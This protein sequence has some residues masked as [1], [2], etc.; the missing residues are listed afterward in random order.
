MRKILRVLGVCVVLGGGAYAGL[1]YYQ[2]SQEEQRIRKAQA[3]AREAA[4]VREKEER[5]L[6]SLRP[7]PDYA[8]LVSP[9]YY[10]PPKSAWQAGEKASYRKLLG[11][12]KFDVLVVPFQ[13]QQQA[14]DRASRSL[15][16][17]HLA[18]ALASSGAS[19][20]DPYVVS[21]ALGDGARG[22]PWSEIELLA[23][24]MGARKIVAGYVGHD[25]KG[26]LRLTIRHGTPGKLAAVTAS[27]TKTFE[28]VPFTDD[29]PPFESFATLLPEVLKAIGTD[30]SKLPALP[31]I[32]WD[33][34]EVLPASPVAM[35]QA[36]ANLAREAGFL[37][38]LAWLT[39]ED[40]ERSRE[41]FAEKAM[42]SV[43]SVAPESLGYAE[44]R[45]RSY[46]LLGYRAAA[47]K[48]LGSSQSREALHLRAMLDGNY[49]E[50]KRL[51][52]AVVRDV[53]ALIARLEQ[54]DIAKTYGAITRKDGEN[55]ARLLKLPP[56]WEYFAVRAF[57]EF[58]DWSQFDNSGLKRIL[59][60]EMP[61]PGASLE[62]ML[63]GVVALGDLSKLQAVRDLAVMEHARKLIEAD[64]QAICC[65]AWSPRLSRLDFVHFVEA[66]ATDNLA[67]RAVF[68]EYIQGTPE[69]ALSFISSIDSIFRDHPR[70]TLARAAAERTIALRSEGVVREGL[71]KSAFL[72]AYHAYRWE[73]GITVTS[74]KAQSLVSIVASSL[75]RSPVPVLNPTFQDYPARAYS[76]RQPPPLGIAEAMT[77]LAHSSYDE[78]P[79]EVLYNLQSNVKKD[80]PAFEATLKSIEHRFQGS[81]KVALLRADSSAR[82][83]DDAAAERLYRE[84]IALQPSNWNAHERLGKM[85]LESGQPAKAA[86]LFR[87]FG[88]FKA[89]S[90]EDPVGIANAAYD[91]G[92]LLY[93]SGNLREASPLYEIAAR[94]KT[95]A[96][97]SLASA[98][99]LAFMKGDLIRG[100]AATIQ[101]VQRY[102]LPLAYRDYFAILHAT[103]SSGPAWDGFNSL[104][105]SVNGPQLWES[106]L[107]GHAVTG[108]TA[109]GIV[110]WISQPRIL[111]TSAE[112]DFPAMHLLRLGVMDRVPSKELAAQLAE[113][114]RPTWRVTWSPQRGMPARTSDVGR[115]WA[116][117]K[118]IRV[119]GPDRGGWSLPLTHAKERVVVK[120]DYEYF[121]TAYRQLRE[122][123]H[124]AAAATIEE[125]AG[126]YDLTLF[127]NA[128]FLPYYAF[129]TAK[130][131]RDVTGV[132]RVMQR[133]A[134]EDR[135]FDYYL[136]AAVLQA[137]TGKHQ[138]AL[139]SLNLARHRRPFTEHR[140]VLTEYQYAETCELLFEATGQ[141]QYRELALRWARNFQAMQPWFAWPYAV[142]AK[143]A[144]N[145]GDRDRAIAM[146]HY[147]DRNSARLASL[148]L[149]TVKAAVSA[150]RGKNPFLRMVAPPQRQDRI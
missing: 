27:N 42:I 106:V 88:G 94:L 65:R 83:G 101:R 11:S 37:Q 14:L 74:A 84:V 131:G 57:A 53:G 115:S 123:D 147:L 32:D 39:P 91:A 136:A 70:L 102:G 63:R 98:A 132:E 95:G 46:L 73:I 110:K 116:D 16:T 97:S 48:V 2:K 3:A 135:R 62:D 44:L 61:L 143:L 129:A 77:V 1:D 121:A 96:D 43:L 111:G 24:Q 145:A 6:R 33:S 140:P 108:T 150:F 90:T 117:G 71:L 75:G 126:L 15:M 82:K 89:G 25:G 12:G 49:P 7:L 41:R 9:H 47:L 144:R 137:V 36:Q 100:A 18:A 20:P 93:W 114:A 17:A 81:P 127:E 59:D 105:G 130:A 51:T 68:L 55:A 99:R 69:R 50:V 26:T 10:V 35:L 141:D 78:R 23:S 31:R 21:K 109:P 148:P 92:S 56:P 13:V 86:A 104:I 29:A 34:R 112:L 38:L 120:S 4:A 5:E 79:V 125:A 54:N 76:L 138:A 103:G 119:L 139:E 113:V 60:A 87:G 67:R 28:N 30:P 85:L 22:I 107:V 146:T 58:D 149:A 80:G 128:Y 52:P 66:V 64:A 134:P 19:V 142:E 124:A 45:A 122:T 118:S 72:D 133:L 8:T 40:E